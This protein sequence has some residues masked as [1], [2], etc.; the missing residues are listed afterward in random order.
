LNSKHL[1]LQTLQFL[2][3]IGRGGNNDFR[4]KQF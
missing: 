2:L 1:T 3:L 4:F